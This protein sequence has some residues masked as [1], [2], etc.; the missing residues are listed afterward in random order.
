MD[1]V[2]IMI[3]STEMRNLQ[4]EQARGWEKMSSFFGCVEVETLL[5]S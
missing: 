5:D 2:E 1:N 4:K 3:T